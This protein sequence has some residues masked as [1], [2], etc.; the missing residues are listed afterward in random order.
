MRIARDLLDQMIDH[1]RRDLPDECFGALGT[2]D[3]RV[4]QVHPLKNWSR[5]PKFAFENGFDM[6]AVL[7]EIE[8]SGAEFG[9]FYHS[10]PRSEAHPSLTDMG[11]SDLWPGLTWIIVGEVSTEPVV[12]AFRVT[13]HD[14]EEVEL[15]V[16]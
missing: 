6:V 2:Q 16:G 8:E 11:L 5:T 13:R 3:G 9:A 14:V 7:E 12:R 1:A 15:E 4:T 10:H